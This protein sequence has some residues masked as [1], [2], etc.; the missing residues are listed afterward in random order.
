[1]S[2]AVLCIYAV[3]FLVL[4]VLSIP[5]LALATGHRSP[6]VPLLFAILL[7]FFAL[8]ASIAEIIIQSDIDPFDNIS[9]D[10][11]VATQG[12]NTL[13]SSWNIALVFLAFAHL[14]KV[15][16]DN[17]LRSSGNQ[18]TG[19]NPLFTV[20][21]FAAFVLIFVFATTMSGLYI[22][23]LR[24]I[25]D[26][27]L[28][29]IAEINKKGIAYSDVLYAFSAIWY[30]SSIFLGVFAFLAYRTV[31]RAGI[32]DKASHG[33]LNAYSFILTSLFRS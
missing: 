20:A 17:V 15:R 6:Y 22:D 1:M 18:A 8:L 16:A 2:L 31:Q 11:F 29:N 19:L 21:Y 14:I 24:A 27:P 12:I 30:A 9:N 5:A 7:F 23:Y 10:A 25:Y 33:H 4:F 26:G 13:F 32:T 3:V 28:L